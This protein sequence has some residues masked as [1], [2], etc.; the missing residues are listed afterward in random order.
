ML[1]KDDDN[2]LAKHCDLFNKVTLNNFYWIFTCLPNPVQYAL[3][4][5]LIYSSENGGEVNTLIIPTV[6][7]M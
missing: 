6:K 5:F 2:Q 4:A 7:M 3:W 1:K